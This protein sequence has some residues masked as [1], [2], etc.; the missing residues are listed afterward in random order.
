M[1]DAESV[2]PTW[3]PQRDFVD[4]VRHTP[5]A[6]EPAGSARARTPERVVIPVWREKRVPGA[7]SGQG[8]GGAEHPASDGAHRAAL[9]GAMDDEVAAMLALRSDIQEQAFAELG[10]LSAYRPTASGT[11]GDG[12]HSLTRRVPAT[13]SAE[14]VGADAG[15]AST[16]DADELRLRLSR[17]QA[18][19]NRGR[20]ASERTGNGTVTGGDEPPVD[21]EIHDQTP[22]SVR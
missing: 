2:V 15:R 9:S 8:A 11:G 1:R 12:S 19:S 13:S 7:P 20:L 22:E 16:R 21:R 6:G 5:E 18:G 4:P 17:F 3:A 14:V 10:Q